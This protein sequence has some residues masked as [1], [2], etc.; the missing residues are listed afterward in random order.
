[1]RSSGETSQVLPV[2]GRCRGRLNHSVQ[3][4]AD[5]PSSHRA[6]YLS[7]AAG[8]LRHRIG[9]AAGLF[10]LFM[11]IGTLPEALTYPTRARTAWAMYGVEAAVAV[12]AV[13][14]CR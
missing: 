5:P 3:G 6:E 10:V 2:T 7:E 8:T 4:A 1:M 13:V 12:V 11:G 9:V 14:A